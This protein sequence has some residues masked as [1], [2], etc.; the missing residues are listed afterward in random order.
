M[1]H[2]ASERRRT[3]R[4]PVRIQI[5]YQTADQFFKDY[6][7]NLSL[8]GI[9]IETDSPLSVGTHL[10]VQFCLPGMQE[11]ISTDGVVVHRLHVGGGT[12]PRKGGMGIKFSDLDSGSRGILESYLQQG[13]EG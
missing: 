4:V 8:G 11:P 12:N 10:R 7:Q 13:G 1:G 5:Q 3:A 2:E 9:F 6:I